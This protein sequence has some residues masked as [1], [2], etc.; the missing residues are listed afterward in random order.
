MTVKNVTAGG[1]LN[2]ELYDDPDNFL[3]KK[4]RKRKVRIPAAAGQQKVC[5][6]LDQPGT[7]AV[8]VYHDKD[9]DRKLKKHWNLLPREPF[10]LSN[11]PDNP[12]GFPNFS[13]SAFT[14]G[15]L[16]ADIV[17]NLREPE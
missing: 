17:I 16:G 7:Y 5:M 3:F 2:I 13:D 14:T 15:R 8:A 1:A 11:N 4:G 12:N 6:N 9:G 10:G